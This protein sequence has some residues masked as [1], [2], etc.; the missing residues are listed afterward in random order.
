MVDGRAFK[1]KLHAY[2]NYVDKDR[3][4]TGPKPPLSNL[5][6]DRPTENRVTG[7]NL[8]PGDRPISR[9]SAFNLHKA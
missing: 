1:P 5:L 6:D 4:A 8:G 7:P 2:G 9:H 3:S